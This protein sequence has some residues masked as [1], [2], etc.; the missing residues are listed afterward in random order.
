MNP[1]NF[2]PKD[3]IISVYTGKVY[4]VIEND[5]N[6]MAKLLNTQTGIEEDWNASNNPHFKLTISQLQ[7]F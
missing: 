5:K 6:G 3:F 4:E 1:V 7:L 2:K